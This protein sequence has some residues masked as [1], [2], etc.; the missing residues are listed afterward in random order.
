MGT[1]SGKD[2]KISYKTGAGAE[3][4]VTYVTSWDVESSMDIDEA[5]YFGG[6]LTEEGTKEKTP[7]SISW[8]GSIAGAVD[9][10]TSGNQGGLF[11]AHRDAAVVSA[12][13]Y[14]DATSGYT[15][16]AYVESYSVSHAADGKAEFNASLQGNGKLNRIDL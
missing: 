13:F 16:E 11:N 14:L 1:V 7:G 4:F 2:G 3:Q 12:T 9:S 5:A 6:S 15:G 8:S 10:A